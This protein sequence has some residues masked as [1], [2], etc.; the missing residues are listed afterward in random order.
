MDN[1]KKENNEGLEKKFIGDIFEKFKIKQFKRFKKTDEYLKMR[2]E[3]KDGISDTSNI[4][5]FL[6]QY[7][8]NELMR[9]F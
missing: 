7:L 8:T 3:V 5:V 9:K 1:I 6:F 4:D 2:N